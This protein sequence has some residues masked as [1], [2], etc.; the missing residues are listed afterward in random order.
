MRVIFLILAITAAGIVQP[1]AADPILFSMKD[2]TVQRG[3]SFWYAVQVDSDLTGSGVVSFE[4]TLNYDPAAFSIDSIT[5]AG[6]VCASWGVAVTHRQGGAFRVVHAG[7]TPLSGTGSLFLLRVRALAGSGAGG[8]PF[9]FSS[10]LLNEGVPGVQFRNG[11]I[12]ISNVPSITV[13]P[14]NTVLAVGG[15]AQFSAYSGTAPYIWT[16]TD[17][18]VARIDAGGLLTGVQRGTCR[19]VAQDQ[20]GIIDTSGVITV[21]AF[22]L[23]VRDTNYLQGQTVLLPLYITDLTGS[24][25]TSGQ[26]TIAFDANLLTP[27]GVEQSGTLLEGADLLQFNSGSSIVSLTFATPAPITGSGVLIFLRFVATIRTTGWSYMDIREA[28]FNENLPALVDPGYAI[29]NTRSILGV[30]PSSGV[31]VA[32]D[33]VQLTATGSPALPLQWNVSNPALASVSAS[34]VLRALHSGVVRVDVMDGVGATGMSGEYTLYDLRLQGGSGMGSPGDTAVVPFRIGMFGPGVS[35]FQLNVTFDPA[36]FLPVGVSAPGGW[37]TEINTTGSGAVTAAGISASPMTDSG[38]I[39]AVQFRILDGAPIGT[40]T[41]GLASA[42]LN[43][44]VPLPLISSGSIQ[45]GPSGVEGPGEVA[46]DTYLL[47]PN[48]PNPFNPST[49]IRYE[50]PSS[51]DIR[52][53]VTDIA[54]REVAVL[55]QGRQSAGVHT[56]MFDAS[57]L[58]SGIYYCKL[59][60]NTRVLIRPMMLLK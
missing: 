27:A 46:P 23:T 48:Y 10:A 50:L 3:T 8:G 55:Y 26:V 29:V 25:V 22:T 32:G 42:V 41:I 5:T 31:L 1:A 57:G 59:Q 34:G 6:T 33:S 20:T 38:E 16:S 43:E 4:M 54:G 47:L 28:L 36:Y 9:Q 35:S 45:I 12:W 18:T 24:N 40:F 19:V 51:E 30:S 21:R 7:T 15:T 14:D 17:T 60:A 53:L 44:G 49:H 2:T 11:Y 52:I 56:V 39:V 13:V 58:P 37:M